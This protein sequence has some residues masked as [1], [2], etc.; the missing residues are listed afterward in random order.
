MRQT[1]ITPGKQKPR[2]AL[3]NVYPAEGEKLGGLKKREAMEARQVLHSVPRHFLD[4]LAAAKISL[5]STAIGKESHS[6]W[7][8][9]PASLFEEKASCL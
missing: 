8:L 6:S 4:P 9:G 5:D 3:A 7:L 2:M 1:V